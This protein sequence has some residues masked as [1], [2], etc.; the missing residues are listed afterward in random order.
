MNRAYLIMVWL[1]PILSELTSRERFNAAREFN[2]N[3]VSQK[4]YALILGSI[5]GVFIVS[6]LVVAFIKKHRRTKY[7]RN[8]LI[9]NG[10]GTL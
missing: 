8:S 5:L 10:V 6:S 4:W 1:N 7:N 2:N 9:K 3:A